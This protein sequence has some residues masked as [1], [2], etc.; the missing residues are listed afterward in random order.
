MENNIG[1]MSLGNIIANKGFSIP[2]YQRT[3][4]WEEVDCQKLMEDLIKACDKDTKKSIGLIT[5][6]KREDG[7]F[8]IIDGQQRFITLSIISSLLRSNELIDKI[9]FERDIES[10]R[11]NVIKNLLGVNLSENIGFTDGDRIIRNARAINQ[12][13]TKYSATKITW[14]YIKENCFML[15]GTVN[16]D[17]LEEF[18]NLN[19]YKTPFSICDYVRSNLIT[20][21]TFHKDELKKEESL[22][23][24]ALGGHSYKTS[25]AKLYDE[26][27]EILYRKEGAC[28]EGEYENVFYVVSKNC[29]DTTLFKE[30]R[31]NIIFTELLKEVQEKREGYRCNALNLNFDEWIK[32][33]VW[34]GYIKNLL[35]QLQS[36][37][38]KNNFSS[39]KLI[40]DYCKGKEK[41]SFF[42]LITKNVRIEEQTSNELVRILDKN[43]S[44]DNLIFGS[45]KPEEIKKPNL[46]LEALCTAQDNQ[47]TGQSYYSNSS[48]NDCLDLKLNESIVDDC[49]QGAGKYIISRFL[50]EQ[51]RS[52]DSYFKVAP[53]MNF[54]DKENPQFKEW[55]SENDEW[56]VEQLFEN[57]I[58]IPVIQ[59][60]YCMGASISEK[61]DKGED[62]LGFI[63]K[64]FEKEKTVIASTIIIA[65]DKENNRY[66]FDGQ[67][68]TYTIYQLLKYL[69]AEGLQ[70]Y[71]FI[72]RN[73][74]PEEIKE[75]SSY[76][77]ESIL[78]LRQSIRTRCTDIDDEQLISFI[79]NN[80]RFKVKVISEVSAA[81]QFFMDINGGVPLTN[82]EIFKSCLI[83]SIPDENKELF[84]K[85]LENEW[86]NFFYLC[87]NKIYQNIYH[88]KSTYYEEELMEIRFIEFLCRWLHKRD[89]ENSFK[90]ASFDLISSKSDLVHNMSYLKTVDFKKLSTIMDN[91]IDEFKNYDKWFYSFNNEI[92]FC[93][94]SF[95]INSS[96]EKTIVGYSSLKKDCKIELSEKKFMERFIRS[97]SIIGRQRYFQDDN[98]EAIQYYEGD[99]IIDKL[100]K[101]LAQERNFDGLDSY[102]QSNL[103]RAI[104]LLAGYNNW[105]TIRITESFEKITERELPIYYVDYFFNNHCIS[106]YCNI[107]QTYNKVLNKNKDY[108]NTVNQT[109]DA[110][111][112]FLILPPSKPEKLR[113]DMGGIF[114][115]IKKDN[116]YTNTGIVTLC[117]N[118]TREIILNRNN[119]YSI[120]LNSGETT[121]LNKI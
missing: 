115:C 109:Q 39:A 34:I 104:H 52:K 5:L 101:N 65:I 69:K 103:N 25:I 71:K 51:Q 19:A 79:K 15:C 84:V 60:D 43:S 54:E 48:K 45:F 96:G 42:S 74:V 93:Y 102:K 83:S 6:F 78:N 2:M 80:I 55:N 14:E 66:I 21:N 7:L 121:I 46:F 28:K 98:K 12:I 57:N 119:S 29:F 76:I 27:I 49:I 120:R 99:L 110:I 26:V 82:Y 64:S 75:A 37:I 106:S 59:R 17:A 100:F 67:Q 92:E 68:R 24:P 47:A 88:V 22:L 114:K 40:D 108:A 10:E 97:Y 35:L 4:K 38:A 58:Y 23:A 73:D 91:M 11:K 62:F 8:D 117:D 118:S 70:E 61:A 41:A 94:K 107:H 13:I 81:E 3:Y 31:I 111:Y 86:L 77:E 36:E 53:I 95:Q 112:L 32:E 1:A 44:I 30:S 33:L 85:K 89:S 56:T 105:G 18:M 87:K 9:N 20:L 16:D 50:D 90:T 116:Q 63:I 113:L 72:G